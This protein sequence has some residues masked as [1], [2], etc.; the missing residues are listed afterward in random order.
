MAA[1]NTLA[2]HGARPLAERD[3]LR[4]AQALRSATLEVGPAAGRTD[5]DEAEPPSPSDSAGAE[6]FTSMS[7]K[8]E[9][10]EAASSGSQH[11]G[12]PSAAKLLENDLWARYA[13]APPPA[14]ARRPPGDSVGRQRM[15]R[16]LRRTAG[17]RRWCKARRG[18]GKLYWKWRGP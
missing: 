2:S 6:G 17:L 3:R 1:Q 4:I 9:L 8:S 12:P 15:K 14:A 18:T 13:R 10:A 5:G 16:R 11:D 7:L